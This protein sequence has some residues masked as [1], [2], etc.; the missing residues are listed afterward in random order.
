MVKTP[1]LHMFRKPSS[2]AMIN[3]NNAT[4]HG[5]TVDLTTVK[6]NDLYGGGNIPLL[7]GSEKFPWF[8]K[9]HMHDNTSAPRPAVNTG[10]TNNGIYGDSGDLISSSTSAC[11]KYLPRGG[12]GGGSL[13][14][15]AEQPN[16]RIRWSRYKWPPTGLQWAYI[17]TGATPR[18]ADCS[19]CWR[20]A[21]VPSRPPSSY[22]HL[23]NVLSLSS[24][25]DTFRSSAVLGI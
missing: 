7:D 25:N 2:S 15:P 3:N 24:L 9:G 1:L 16:N 22:I 20:P 6:L 23:P 11:L 4:S 14:K 17:A 21:Q 10:V 19:C 8:S 12:S 18:G 5:Q 13:R